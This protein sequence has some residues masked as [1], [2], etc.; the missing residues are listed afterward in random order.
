MLIMARSGDRQS[1]VSS[2]RGV[3]VFMRRVMPE[4]L[5]SSA[6]EPS[7]RSR[8]Y[9]RSSATESTVYHN[10]TNGDRTHHLG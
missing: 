2:Q 4:Q 3:G 7:W 1:H 5:Q 10:R 8:Q 6:A 9:Q